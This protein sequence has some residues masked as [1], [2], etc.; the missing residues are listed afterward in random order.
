MED[1]E[2]EGEGEEEGRGKVRGRRVLRSHARTSV[3]CL[4]RKFKR[5]IYEW[6][7]QAYMYGYEIVNG[8]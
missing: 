1:V 6:N 4:V 7:C 8:D 5:N 3:T 2:E